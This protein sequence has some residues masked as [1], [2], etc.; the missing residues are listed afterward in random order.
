MS[1]HRFGVDRG[2]KVTN[3]AALVHHEDETI[4]MAEKTDAN[5]QVENSICIFIKLE[6]KA[7]VLKNNFV[8]QCVICKEE[9]GDVQVA[10]VTGFCCL[11]YWI[12]SF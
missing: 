3:V 12:C 10:W 4:N 5:V 1:I 6:L 2:G 11:A 7:V 9:D 8:L